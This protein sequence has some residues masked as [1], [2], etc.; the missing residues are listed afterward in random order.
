MVA[1]G[2]QRAAQA[3]CNFGVWR[4]AHKRFFRG[5]PLGTTTSERRYAQPNAAGG[6]TGMVAP[7]FC[8]NHAVRGGAQHG[9]FGWCPLPNLRCELGIV[10]WSARAYPSSPK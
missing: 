5:R 1:H 10:R 4:G 3:L 9:V 6:D 8:A 2:N 7:E